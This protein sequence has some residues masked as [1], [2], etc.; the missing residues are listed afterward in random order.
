MLFFCTST[1]FQLV[2]GDPI[3]N[4]NHHSLTF[5]FIYAKYESIALVYITD[6]LKN[7]FASDQN[8]TF[9]L[10]AQYLEMH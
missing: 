2:F 5:Y 7:Y 9:L 8:F 4:E 6:M 1:V 10:L 3:P